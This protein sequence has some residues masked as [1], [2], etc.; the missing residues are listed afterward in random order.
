MKRLLIAAAPL[1]ATLAL[2][3]PAQA[4]TYDV[5]FCASSGTVFDNRSWA[6]LASPPIAVDTTCPAA[7]NPI[8]VGAS[9][10]A[11]SAAGAAAGLTFTSPAGTAITD[12]ALSRSLTYSNPAV[13]GARPFYT[14]YQLGTI[15]FAGAGDYDDVTRNRLNAQRSWYGYPANPAS[16]PRADVTRRNFPALTAYRN[17]ARTLLVRIGCYRRDTAPCQ[18]GPGGRILN[19]LFGA[20][21]TVSDPTPPANASVEASGLLAGG[22]RDGSD[23]VTVSA[24]DNA[25]IKKIEIVDFTDPAAPRVVGAENYDVGF[26]YEA[27]EPRTDR[28]T[29]CSFRL[30]KP[31]PD[32][33]RETLRA[34]SLQ[35]G[36]R[37]LV[38]R[39]TDAGGNV[40]DRGPY[41]VDVSTP[42][43]RGAP[44]GIGVKEPARVILRY[45][46]TKR[47]RQTVRYYRKVGIRGRL[48]NADGNPIAGAELRLLTRDLRQGASAIDRRGVRTRSDGSFRVTVRAKAS[49]QLQ[50]A[51][52]ARAN[53]ARF[54][55]NSYLTLRARAAGT[56]RVRPRA[57]G[58]GRS[59]RLTGRLKGVRRAGVPIV[60]QGKLRGARR[61]QTFADT[62][63]SRRGTFSGRYTFRSAGSRGRE[64]VF[65]ARIRRAPG[66]PYET[67]STRTVRVR[68]R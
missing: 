10:G 32:L 11:R 48:I 53:D 30:A 9:A 29:T 52:R 45:S 7:G 65:R 58:V 6:A 35:V 42:S 17:N 49:R 36:R 12:F 63:S 15:V 27:G 26:T 51:W 66:F 8:A 18:V 62:S 46:N 2:A 64:F 38:I 37:T 13:S 56:L 14:L 33:S 1:A 59:V 21:V 31:C 25:G 61:F 5:H 44:N 23:P 22:F 55:A 40:V 20:R 68:V 28:G 50:F 34:S 67:G 41:T 19:S 4:G 3:A 47:P 54:A 43:D 60:L 39:F 16:L 57:T 24:T